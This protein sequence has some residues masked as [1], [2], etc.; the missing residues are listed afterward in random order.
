MIPLLYAGALGGALR[1]IVTLKLLI[2][3][4]FY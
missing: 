4:D 3:L 1:P 2:T